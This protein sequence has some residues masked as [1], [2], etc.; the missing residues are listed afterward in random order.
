METKNR[1]IILAG[2]DTDI[3][4]MIRLLSVST[5]NDMKN[6]IHQ[7]KVEQKR[8]FYGDVK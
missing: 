4:H 6:I 7:L 8:L 3:D 1:Q 5:S 2:K